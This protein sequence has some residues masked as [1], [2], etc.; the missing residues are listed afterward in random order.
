MKIPEKIYFTPTFWIKNLFYSIRDFFN[1]RQKWLTKK[2]P[3]SW[4]DK[5]WLIQL[6]AFE[7]IVHFIEEEEAFD[8]IDWS[9]TQ[10]HKEAAEAFKRAYQYV[11]IRIPILE[12]KN[13]K[14]WNNKDLRDYFDNGFIV[15]LPSQ[16]GNKHKGHTLATP[17][18]KASEILAQIRENDKE[19]EWLTQETVEIV[20]KYRKFM[21]T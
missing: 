14:L 12:E 11:K 1:P 5:V 18:P 16:D 20:A 13:E 2:I 19:I 4:A 6:V 17:P 9:A 3:R 8:H 7:S 21:W 10:E 15:S